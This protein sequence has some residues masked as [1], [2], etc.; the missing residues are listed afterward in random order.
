MLRDR[1]G[2]VLVL[3]MWALM[4]LTLFSISISYSVQRRVA[5]LSRL[6][7]LDALYPVA[8]S[9]VEVCKSLIADDSQKDIDTLSDVWASVPA[10]DPSELKNGSF[11]IGDGKRNGL[12]DEESKVNL[13]KAK[14]D[15]LARLLQQV[16]KINKDEAEELA[17]CLIDWM[18][19]DSFFG[20]PDYGAED[21]T[22]ESL[23]KPYSA[24]D[25]KYELLDEMLLVSGMNIDI[26]EAIKPYV[27]VHGMGHINLN[28]ASR[29]VL[30]SLGLSPE[31]CDKIVR[32]RSGPDGRDGTGDDQYFQNL[33][34]IV[35]D[36]DKS[37]GTPTDLTQK[38]ILDGLSAAGDV[39]L[40]SSVF[41]ARI[42]ARLEKNN[43]SVE[44]D[45]V[46]D[47]KGKVKLARSSG[48]LWPAR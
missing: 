27:T 21:S 18:D 36:L 47:R 31:F 5:L 11:V 35:D 40:Y 17:Y 4:I 6:Q 38:A 12:V 22:Y 26:F 44:L 30:L 3:A 48:V 39:A 9:G 2:S 32:Y 16:T 1:R 20:H 19:S 34:A 25:S 24:K 29:P 46:M 45:A 7:T 42:V 15:V 41:S 37:G 10:S 43:A 23:D 13:N 33:P 28:T 8:Y 14:P